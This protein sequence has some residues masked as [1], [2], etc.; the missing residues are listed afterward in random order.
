MSEPS[1]VVYVISTIISCAGPKI[2]NCLFA[3][4]IPTHFES[5]YPKRFFFFFFLHFWKIF[6][7]WPHFHQKIIVTI[8]PLRRNVRKKMH[9]FS[10]LPNQNIQGRGTANKQIFK[11][12]PGSIVC[13]PFPYGVWGLMWN[14]I[15]S[16]PYHRLFI[17]F[18]K[19]HTQPSRG[20]T[21]LVVC[22]RLPLVL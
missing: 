1:L 3:V 12:G 20:A 4:S 18:P 17:C 8:F 10:Y 6:F 11:N 15:V 19:L 7:F 16:V 21:S 22:L 2:K 13:I 9:F 14:S 5:P